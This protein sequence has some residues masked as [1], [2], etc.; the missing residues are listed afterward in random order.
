MVNPSKVIGLRHSEHSITLYALSTCIWC[1]RTKKLLN[2]LG[3][4]YE[5]INVDE[6]SG[7]DKAEV[8][9]ELAKFN[10]GRTFPTM[11]IDNSKS[12]VGFKENQ[13]REALLR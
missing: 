1:K 3:L 7:Q 5:F 2:D 8:L 11:V 9:E 4:P 6:L 13:I 12:I 10:P